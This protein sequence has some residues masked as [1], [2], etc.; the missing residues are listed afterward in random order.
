M[1]RNMHISRRGGARALLGGMLLLLTRGTAS[2][3]TD[4]D[5]RRALRCLFSVLPSA[6]AIGAAYLRSRAPDGLD[7][8]TLAATLPTG[9]T[10]VE[11]RSAIAARVRDDF[12]NARVETVDGWMLATTEARLCALAYL[13]A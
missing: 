11:L 10:V 2:A 12:A 8:N 1:K 7:A 9:L 13:V 3:A 5:T 4:C 6:R